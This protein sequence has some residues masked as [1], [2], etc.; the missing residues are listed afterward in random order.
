MEEFIEIKNQQRH[1]PVLGK[2][3]TFI[4]VE[5]GRDSV[6]DFESDYDDVTIS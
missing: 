1:I 2:E 4:D 5:A 6:R 3:A